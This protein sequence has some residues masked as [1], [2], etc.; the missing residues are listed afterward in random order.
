MD[1]EAD[2]NQSIS[3]DFDFDKQ[4]GNYVKNCVRCGGQ[5]IISSDELNSFINDDSNRSKIFV[6]LQCDSCSLTLNVLLL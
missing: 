6:C 3:K 5:F 2:V 1:H 4:N